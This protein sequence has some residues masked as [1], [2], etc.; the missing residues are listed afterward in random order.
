MSLAEFQENWKEFSQLLQQVGTH[1]DERLNL[2]TQRC[3]E[4]NVNVLND[5]LTTSIAN[6]KKLQQIKTPNEAICTQARFT[7]EI[8]HKLSL[9]AQRF[10]NASLGHIADYNDWLKAHCDFAT[11]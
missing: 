2:L 6:L 9:S 4:Q 8:S 10:L 1:G 7:N 11:D 5:V 3:V